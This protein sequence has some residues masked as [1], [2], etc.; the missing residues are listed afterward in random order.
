MPGQHAILMAQTARLRVSWLVVILC[1]FSKESDL[2]KQT[3]VKDRAVCVRRKRPGCR[4]T[5]GAWTASMLPASVA[6][7]SS[8]YFKFFE[9]V[10]IASA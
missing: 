4:L 10:S 3:V 7:F 1:L 2:S 6:P 8:A 9:S 5:H